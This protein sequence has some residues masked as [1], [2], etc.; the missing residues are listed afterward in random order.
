MF[1]LA[2][3]LLLLCSLSACGREST[4]LYLSYSP[5]SFQ[6]AEGNPLPD[7]GAQNRR[8]L[9]AGEAPSY[10]YVAPSEEAPS[11]DAE[12]EETTSETEEAPAATPDALD[13]DAALPGDALARAEKKFNDLVET[14]ESLLEKKSP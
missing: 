4:D 7:L 3:S 6:D 9:Q 14:F 5:P 10:Y 13:A 12:S 8:S 11:S 1:R 2:L